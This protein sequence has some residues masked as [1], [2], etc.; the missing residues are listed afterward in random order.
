MCGIAIHFRT[1]G[2]AARLDLA[3]L[4]HRGPD[5]SGEWTSP[6]GRCWLGSTRLAIVDLSPSG[7]Q[8][9]IDA[10]TGNVIVHNG[11]IYNHGE[12]RKQ[13]GGITW[14]GTSDTETILRG[15]ARWGS[16]VVERLKGMFAFAIYDPARRELLV[17]RDRFGIKPLYYAVD[18][19][20]VRFASEVKALVPDGESTTADRISAYLQWGA[21]PERKLLYPNLLSLAAGHAISILPDG[22]HELWRYWPTE[23]SLQPRAGNAR[24]IRG[25][26]ERAVEEHLLSDVPV[27]SFLSGGIDSSIVTALAAQ[28]LERKLQTFSVG[29]DDATLDESKIA[30]EVAQRYGTDHHSIRLSEKQV[31]ESVTEAVSKLDLPSVDAINTFVVSKA[32][33]RHGIKVALSGLGG[34]ELFGGYPSFRDV[35]KLKF[36]SRLPRAARQVLGGFGTV[37]QRVADLPDTGSTGELARWRRRFFT[38]A[39]LRRAQLPNSPAPEGFDCPVELRDDFAA[40]SWAEMTGYMRRMLLR[41]ADQMSMAVSLELRVPFLDHELVEHVLSLPAREKQSRHGGTKTWLVELCRDLLPVSVYDRPKR[42]FVLPMKSWMQGPLAEFVNDGLREAAGRK[43]LP[44]AFIDELR[45]AFTHGRLHWTRLWAIVTLGH[46]A[47]RRQLL[48]SVHEDSALHS[49]A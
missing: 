11:E 16:G 45:A 39:M 5:S 27:A 36:L 33:A 25:L 31:I 4:R 9:M 49:L 34:D 46:F 18:P 41:D 20:G 30:L 21:S 23:K 28:R 3:R 1:S 32:V 26:L 2:A 40:I 10:T 17:A 42:G 47:K 37:G 22:R 13:L 24:N 19:D 7:A 12:L 15:Y 35:P 48:R 43:L 44:R 38:D 14:Q 8:P 29:F 6:D